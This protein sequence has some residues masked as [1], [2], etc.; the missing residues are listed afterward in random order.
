MLPI[1][2]R[3]DLNL[4]K[5]GSHMTHCLQKGSKQ[6]RK[7]I[8]LIGESFSTHSMTLMIN[9]LSQALTA[10]SHCQTGYS[11]WWRTKLTKLHTKTKISANHQV[12]RMPSFWHSG[13]KKWLILLSLSIKIAPWTP[14]RILIRECSLPRKSMKTR[15]SKLTHSCSFK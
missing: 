3:L 4:I 10:R 12:D 13:L 7:R 15:Y 8:K 11:T 1:H 2:Q 9:L 5:L 14:S 6:T